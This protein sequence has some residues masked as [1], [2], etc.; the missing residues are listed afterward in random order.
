[1]PAAPHADAVVVMGRVLAPYGV[2]GWVRIRAFTAAPDA[3]TGYARWWLKPADSAAWRE[4][5]CEAAR[6]HAGGLVAKLDGISTREAAL[7][8]RGAQVGVNRSALPAPGQDELY[9]TDLVGLD[10]V[11]REGVVLGRVLA[12]EEYGAHPLLRVAAPGEGAPTRATAPM[13]IPFVAAHVDGVDRSAGRI[14]VD[15]QA[16]YC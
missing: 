9:W 11:N 6:T 7:A 3:L 12:V 1:V 13:L 8:L 2:H 4:V 14:E 5:A 15:W 16:D 10:V